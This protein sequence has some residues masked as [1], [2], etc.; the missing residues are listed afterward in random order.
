MKKLILLGCIVFNVFTFSC[1]DKL[2]H[3]AVEELENENFVKVREYDVLI[4]DAFWNNFDFEDKEQ[5]INILF[6]YS[7][8]HTQ[9]GI[10][11]Y[12]SKK[13]GKILAKYGLMGV[14]I[15]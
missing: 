2:L 3:G 8:E 10:Y 13:T 14:S 7:K 11:E 1:A 4:D 9:S 5:I 12:K 6:A 15:K